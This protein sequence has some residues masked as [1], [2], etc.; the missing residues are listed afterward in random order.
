MT[1]EYG[2][3]GSIAV[4]RGQARLAPLACLLVMALALGACGAAPQAQRGGGAS[5]DAHGG[6]IPGGGMAVRPCP[7]QVGDAQSMGPLSLTLTQSDVTGSMRVGE[8][9]Q[10][11]LPSTLHWTLTTPSTLLS[12]VG[13]AGGQDSSLNVCYWTFRAQSAGSATL[14]FS[15][16]VPCD[17]PGACSNAIT[18]QTFTVTVS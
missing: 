11:R 16:A 4:W 5:S 7:A 18:Q 8:F 9:A 2:M 14:A 13:P 6:S 12:S 17:N 10:V 1:E 15:G 3:L